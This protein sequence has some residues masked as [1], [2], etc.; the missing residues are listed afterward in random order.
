MG[1]E[2][3]QTPCQLPLLALPHVPDRLREM[4]D[5]QLGSL[6]E[7]SSAACSFAQAMMSVS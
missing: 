6:P 3:R 4:I 1:E 2:E 7:R 5:V